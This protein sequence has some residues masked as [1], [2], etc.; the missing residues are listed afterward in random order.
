MKGRIHPHL[1]ADRE[2]AARLSTGVTHTTSLIKIF[3]LP[4]I[5]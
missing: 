1:R 3:Q 5:L 4:L 2:Q